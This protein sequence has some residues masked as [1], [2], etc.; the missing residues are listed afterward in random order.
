MTDP[1][2]LP[3]RRRILRSG[4]DLAEAGV[5][6]PERVAEIDAVAAR[7]ALAVTP[8]LLDLIDPSD[9]ADPIARQFVPDASEL[10]TGAHE[11]AD[12]IGDGVHAPV[13]G[14]VH[15]YPDRVLLIPILHCP[16]YCRFCF[17]REQVGGAEAALSE[18]ELARALAY[19]RTHDQIWEV[20]ITGG[21]PLM[22]PAP[23]LATLVAEL[24]AISH[25]R[26][27][28][29]HS[30]VPISDPGRIGPGLLAALDA[31]TALWIAIHCNHARELTPAAQAACRQLNR[32]G[33]PLL[34]QTVLLKGVNDEPAVMEELM[35]AMVVNRIKPY[36]LHHLDPAPGVARF[37]TAI[38]EGQAVMRRLRGR[39]S[40]LCQPTYVLDIPGGHG[41]VP[42]GPVYLEGLSVIDWQGRRHPFPPPPQA[43]A[44]PPGTVSGEPV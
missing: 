30:R 2:S 21:D 35:R 44:D 1:T 24:D 8:G 40:G 25:V 10:T 38:A 16:V 20:V 15:R 33:I 6:P 29:L 7:Y 26:V 18:T 17:R 23:R 28:R 39:A 14:I 27:I 32:A 13:K 19:I 36:Y 22:L 11:L 12:P 34:G 5:V 31:E 42:I 4:K 43:V 3:A 9:P 37:R 41:K